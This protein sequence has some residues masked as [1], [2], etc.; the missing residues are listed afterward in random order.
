MNG[1]IESILDVYKEMVLLCISNDEY[2]LNV[3]NMK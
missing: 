1:D 2:V 3:I